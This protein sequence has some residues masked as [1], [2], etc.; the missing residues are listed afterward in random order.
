MNTTFTEN[1]HL[2]NTITVTGE[3]RM[4]LVPDTAVIRIGVQTDG[5]NL[6]EIQAENAERIQAVIQGLRRAGIEDIKTFQYTIN[7][8]IDFEDG[9]QIDRGFSVRNILEIRTE[10]I[11]QA[12]MIID[13]AVNSGANIVELI[14]FEVS[15]RDYYYQQALNLAVANAVLKANSIAASLG[16][17]MDPTPRRIIENTVPQFRPL[18]IQ[19]EFAAT[20]IVPGDIEIEASVTAVFFY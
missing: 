8:V 17:I 11:N 2:N 5:I 3:G 20:E 10:N 9:T 14:S 1:Q 7:K 15:N 13:T 12:G 16:I 6:T 18:T 4:A 19:R